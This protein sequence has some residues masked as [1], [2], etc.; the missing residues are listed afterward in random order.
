LA[1]SNKDDSNF[2]VIICP[3]VDQGLKTCV[4]ETYDQETCVSETYDQE[5]DQ[6]HEH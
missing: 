5:N 1:A 6:T 4:S 3:Q 2:N